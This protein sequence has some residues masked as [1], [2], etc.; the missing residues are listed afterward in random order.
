MYSINFL[1]LMLPKKIPGKVMVPKQLVIDADSACI[2]SKV[3]L[4]GLRFPLGECFFYSFF[5]SIAMKKVALIG[6]PS[7]PF[8][9][10]VREPRMQL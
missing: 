2:S 10:K 1:S 8:A 6:L 4:S 5:K 3:A 9:G 7:F